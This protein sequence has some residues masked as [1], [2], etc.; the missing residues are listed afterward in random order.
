MKYLA[1][2]LFLVM[3]V[4]NHSTFSAENTVTKNTPAAKS[5]ADSLNSI[6]TDVG[7]ITAAIYPLVVAQRALSKEEIATIDESVSQ[8]AE[9][10]LASEPYIVKKPDGYQ[11]SYEFVSEYL[12]VVKTV[13]QIAP[14][15]YARSHLYALGEICASCH[16]QDTI[17]RTLFNGTTREAF[18]DDYAFAE[19]NYITREYDVAVDYYEKF[20]NSPGRKTE[21]NI[22]QPLQRIVTVYIQMQNNPRQAIKVLEK[23]TTYK[24]HSPVTLA[25]VDNWI[26]GLESLVASGAGEVETL[27][28]NDLE[29]YVAK[30]L[31]GTEELSFDIQSTAQQEVQRVWLRGRLYHYLNRQP[32]DTEIPM[33]LYWLSVLDR[34]IAYNFYFSLAE[35]Y[36]KQCVLHYPKHPYAQRCFTEFE[37][38]V[39]HTY[40]QQ[41]EKIPPGIQLELI[42]MRDAL[43][44][45]RATK[46]T[47]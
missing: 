46:I 27:T 28:F 16:T 36:L 30:Y 18:S 4:Y 41:G 21:L 25:E 17:L 19:L 14:I 22:I 10:F 3:V 33:L 43:A 37:N 26:L 24:H 1:L 31:G 40:V 8:L 47:K 23:Y 39:D 20:L 5:P 32:K 6:M 34:S 35:L 2:L 29:K 13:L 12:K 42:E 7:K 15:D 44:R 11:V 9:L 45:N 38:Y